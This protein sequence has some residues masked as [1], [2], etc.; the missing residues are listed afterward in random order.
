MLCYKCLAKNIM[1][2]QTSV[3]KASI[4]TRLVYPVTET[5]VK[6]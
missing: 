2:H 4:E 5:K 3:Y 1:I 6:G